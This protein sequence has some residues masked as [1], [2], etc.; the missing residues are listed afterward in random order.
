VKGRLLD[1]TIPAGVSNSV[2]A[3]EMFSEIRRQLLE[4]W[5]LILPI[6]SVDDLHHDNETMS[7]QIIKNL[8][9]T[10]LQEVYEHI[11]QGNMTI[12]VSV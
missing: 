9:G 5:P 3:H 4:P 2:F 10:T 6:E 8:H 12:S 7:I 11:Q 1:D